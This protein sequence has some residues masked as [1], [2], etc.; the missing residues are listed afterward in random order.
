MAPGN[1][2]L[3][4][5]LRSVAPALAT[6]NAVVLK[7]ASDTTICCGVVIARLFEEA[8]LPSG[9]LPASPTACE[10]AIPARTSIWARSSTPA[11]PTGSKPS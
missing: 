10:S 1:F 6:G 9:V 7:T 11:R 8:G 2:P 4:L 3:V 5:A